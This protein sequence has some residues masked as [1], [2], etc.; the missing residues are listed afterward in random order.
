Y[1]TVDAKNELPDPVDLANKVT[2]A[3]CFKLPDLV[4]LRDETT[5]DS[6]SG[7]LYVTVQNQGTEYARPST[8]RV[9]FAGADQFKDAETKGLE[10]GEKIKL[11]FDIP[12]ALSGKSFNYTINLDWYKVVEESN[13]DNNVLHRS[14]G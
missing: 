6:A 14:C 3:V 11:T 2:R 12:S 9:Q 4:P 7:K 8:T 5:C 1:I 10:P 13:K